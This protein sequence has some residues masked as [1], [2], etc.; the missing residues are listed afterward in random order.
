MQVIIC[1]S[2]LQ[3][4]ENPPIHIANAIKPVKHEKMLI[5]E[6]IS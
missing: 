1:Q 2:Q 3:W 4:M 6:T 5:Y